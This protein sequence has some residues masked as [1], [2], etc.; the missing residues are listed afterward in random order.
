MFKVFSKL[1]HSVILWSA[2]PFPIQKVP[3]QFRVDVLEREMCPA[4]FL[5]LLTEEHREIFKCLWKQWGKLCPQVLILLL[6]S[7]P[8]LGK[9]LGA[10][11]GTI[12]ALAAGLGAAPEEWE[13]LPTVFGIPGSARDIWLPPP[14]SRFIPNK[15]SCFNVLSFVGISSKHE[16]PIT[17][18]KLGG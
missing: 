14:S 3:F 11:L 12:P 4:A 1:N 2:G 5:H 6:G 17:A 7:N 8:V 9:F 10:L 18:L 16:F 15:A 13:A